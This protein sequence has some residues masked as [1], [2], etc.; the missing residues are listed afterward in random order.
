MV[1]QCVLLVDLGCSGRCCNSK[2]KQLKV[3]FTVTAYKAFFSRASTP[4]YVQPGKLAKTFSTV[5][6]LVQLVGNSRRLTACSMVNSYVADEMIGTPETSSTDL[7]PML[8]STDVSMTF[9]NLM[10]P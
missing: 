7:A 3:F 2:P 8:H 9:L 4:M 6:A 1:Q 5:L 10:F